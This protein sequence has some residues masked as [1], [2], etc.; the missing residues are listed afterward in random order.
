MSKIARHS[1]QTSAPHAKSLHIQSFRAAV[2]Y[3]SLQM[4]FKYKLQCQECVWAPG[5]AHRPLR[6]TSCSES[7]SVRRVYLIPIGT[8][9]TSVRSLSLPGDRCDPHHIHYTYSTPDSH[10]TIG[11]SRSQN[12]IPCQHCQRDNIDRV[13]VNKDRLRAHGLETHDN[14]KCA[15]KNGKGE[16]LCL[17]LT[18]YF[19]YQHCCLGYYTLKRHGLSCKTLDVCPA[20]GEKFGTMM[21]R[22]VV[23]HF[24]VDN[25]DV[26]ISH[27]WPSENSF[28]PFLCISGETKAS[29]HQL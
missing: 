26:R 7:R 25:L 17:L 10:N 1:S 29:A 8:V 11:K 9:N 5:S 6:T 18:L 13:Y 4:Y 19:L 15:F 16:W 28:L 3:P 14:V 2:R 24:N 12:M 21:K 20:C 22:N 23:P 27:S